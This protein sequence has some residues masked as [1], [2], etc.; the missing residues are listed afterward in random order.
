[1]RVRMHTREPE[2]GWDFARNSPFFALARGLWL[3][4]MSRLVDL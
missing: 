1:M 3:E 2:E 4:F